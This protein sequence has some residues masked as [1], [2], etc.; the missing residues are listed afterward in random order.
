MSTPRPFPVA[1]ATG[2]VVLEA[3][4]VGVLGIVVGVDAARGQATNAGAAAFLTACGVLVGIGLLLVSRGLLY[5][6]RWGR[7]PA[8]LAQIIAIPVA[9]ALGQG[10]QYALGVPLGVLAIA[11]AVALLSPP[12]TRALV[13]EGT[14][15]SERRTDRT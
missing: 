7:A 9:V 6:R 4:F 3:V 10:G 13:G 12:T 15:T 8:L 1:L 5:C 11:A 14:R 2:V